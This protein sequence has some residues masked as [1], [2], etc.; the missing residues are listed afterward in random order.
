MIFACLYCVGNV[1]SPNDAWNKS[2]TLCL[3]V[4]YVIFQTT[5]GRPSS[6]GAF[7]DLAVKSCLSISSM[8][9]VGIL[10]GSLYGLVPS[11]SIPSGRGGKNL[12]NSSSAC[13]LW[14]AVVVLSALTSC[15]SFP[16]A[17]SSPD[18]RY[19]AAF[20]IFSLS[21]R[22]SFQCFFFCLRM[23]SWYC[24]AASWAIFSSL[25]IF[26]P[27]RRSERARLR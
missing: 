1:P 5:A 8:P 19:L 7:H 17:A 11:S 16:N 26:R 10:T 14:L 25:G 12:D 4:G 13:S 2:R 15:G 21:A 24:F 6:P 22:N 3:T 9:T 23:A 20:Q 27:A 18:S